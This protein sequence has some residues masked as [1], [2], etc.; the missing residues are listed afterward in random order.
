MKWKTIYF[1]KGKKATTNLLKEKRKKG[2][3][4]SS[5]EIN[6]VQV[7]FLSFLLAIAELC[8][9]LRSVPQYKIT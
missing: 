1:R 2:E 8:Q 4:T 6:E 5:R 7:L 3:E 9:E